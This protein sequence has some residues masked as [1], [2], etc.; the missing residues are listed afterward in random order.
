MPIYEYHCEACEEEF[1]DLVRMG[2]PDDAIVCPRCGE[3][4]S[5]RLLSMFAGR[6]AGGATSSSSSS[7]GGG[8]G[9]R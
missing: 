3:R 2:T 5:R 9:F 1:E 6:T 8:S 4:R 7:C